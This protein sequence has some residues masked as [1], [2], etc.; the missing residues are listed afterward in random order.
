MSET[1]TPENPSNKIDVKGLLATV[2]QR[3]WLLICRALEA[4]KDDVLEQSELLLPA[5]CWIN[6]KRTKGAVADWEQVLDLLDSD[7][8][9]ELGVD[10]SAEGS[11][12]EQPEG[13]EPSES[14]TSTVEPS[15]FDSPSIG[16]VD[17]PTTS[18]QSKPN[19]DSIER[20]FASA[21]AAPSPSTTT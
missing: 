5:L 21:P 14:G 17:S 19:G 7:L 13:K 9:A 18:P 15:S 12:D 2:T 1:Q 11:E 20:G 4:S 6:R 3:E 8:L 16:P 10:S